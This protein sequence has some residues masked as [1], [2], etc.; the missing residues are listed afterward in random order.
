ML[1]ELV[2]GAG[3]G[4]IGVFGE[5][6]AITS[7]DFDSRQVRTGS[8]FCCLRGAQSDG[9]AF[10][11]GAREAGAAALLVDHRVDV[12]LPQIIVPDTR[13]AMGWLAASFFQHPSR[14]L[15]LVGVTGTNGKTTTTSLVASIMRSSGSPTGMIG[16]LTGAHTTPESPDL[17]SRLAQFVDQGITGVVIE[18]SSHALEL[19]RVAGCH[20]DMAI[21][22]NLG[23]DHLDLHGTQERYFAAKARLF[24]PDLSDAAVVNVDD[25]H[26]R[27][28]MDVGAIPTEGYSLDD[29]AEVFV[30]ATHHSYTWRGQAIEVPIGGEF[31]VMNSLAAATACARLGIDLVE[32]AK[33]LSR[34]E[35]VPGRFEAVVAGQPFAVIVDYAHTPEGLEKAIGAARLVAGDAQVHVVFGCGG[36]R[37]REKRP[38]MGA[39]ASRLADHV[40]ITSDN[41]RSEDPLDIINAAVKGVPDDYRGRVV[42]EP[43]RRRAIEIAVRRARSGDVVLIAGKGHEPTQTI[44]DQVLEFDDR[45]VAREILQALR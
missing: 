45:A 30:S 4:Q 23:R 6:V 5:D 11:A 31:N 35:T 22:T 18:V 38:L 16:T 10:A 34:A 33:G 39:V 21:F 27:L 17:Q 43:D 3:L 20:F 24:Q 2:E 26:G 14:R 29:V 40:V 15:R 32:I 8:L 42:M 1:R 36:D 25:P 41:P 37:D 19:Q 28:L 7:I 13:L 12:D 9:H 44:G